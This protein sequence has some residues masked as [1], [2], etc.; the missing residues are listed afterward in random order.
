MPAAAPVTVN[1]PEFA[2]RLANAIIYPDPVSYP[3]I[4]TVQVQTRFDSDNLTAVPSVS[5]T[6]IYPKT[7]LLVSDVN[8]GQIN[9]SPFGDNAASDAF[10]RLRVGLPA[11]QLDSK[12]L[13]DKLPAI[14]D[15]K[16][17]LGSSTFIAGDSL[18]SMQTSA[19]SGYVIR[20]T[21]NRFNYQ[22]GKSMTAS[23]TF[24]AAP[25]TNIV[26]RIGLFQGLSAAPYVPSDGLY[27]EITENG[28]SFNV[29]KTLNGTTT[30]TTIPQSGWN[31]D[32]L[33]GTGASGLTIDFTK[34]QIFSL[35]Y[36]WLGLG[37][38]RFGFY[39]YG[40]LYYAHH[41]N[42]FNTLTS[43]YITSPNQPVRYEIR[44]IG[45]G[46]GTLKQICSTVID[47][48]VPEQ[49]GTATTASTSGTIT[50][51]NGVMTP[52][53]A[54]RLKPDRS[55]LSLSLKD[56]F[57]YNT[58][59]TSNAKYTLYRGASVTGGSLSWNEVDNAELQYAYGSSSLSVSGGYPLYSGF[60]PKSQGTASGTGVQN[61]E[62]LVGTFGTKIDGTPETL[63]IAVL[64]LGAT[65]AVYAAANTFINS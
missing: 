25:E 16:I 60:I 29:V 63:T 4:S 47:E 54:L 22:P 46:S 57:I 50:A 35:D 39:L 30:T 9:G 33:N 26:K 28:P 24:V 59:N 12:M 48:G 51:Q 45:V 23:L 6:Y 21:M 15:E 58:D 56:F 8:Y 13:Y 2:S 43:P 44:Q 52:I 32:K 36:E 31:V 62:E 64:G 7:A 5:T 61:I 27:L 17:N 55:N 34:G 18:V 3:A 19:V 11:T 42:N 1:Y 40:K 38:V 49:L 41:I 53:L 14:F 65:V 10:G 37:R 20:Q